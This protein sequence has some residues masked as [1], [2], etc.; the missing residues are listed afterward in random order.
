MVLVGIPEIR[1]VSDHCILH[2]KLCH[3]SGDGRNGYQ[4]PGKAELVRIQHFRIEQYHI[5]EAQPD[6]DISEQ[7]IERGLTCYD[8]HFEFEMGLSEHCMRF[9]R[10]PLAPTKD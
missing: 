3:L 2:P 1:E 8:A 4:Q 6:P 10:V 5:D 9:M 7:G